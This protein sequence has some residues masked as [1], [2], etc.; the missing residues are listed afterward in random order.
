MEIINK[1]CKNT[2]WKFCVSMSLAKYIRDSSNVDTF[3]S[4]W[5]IRLSHILSYFVSLSSHF[6]SLCLYKLFTSAVGLDLIT[7]R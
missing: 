2:N 1:Q 6:E 5:I 7:G 4:F 3:Y